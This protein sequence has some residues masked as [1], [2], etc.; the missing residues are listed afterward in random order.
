MR[1]LLTLLVAVAFAAPAS[2]AQEGANDFTLEDFEGDT[3]DKWQNSVSPE[4]Y[5]GGEGRKGLEFIQDPERGGVMQALVAFVDPNKSEPVWITRFIDDPIPLRQILTVSFW[6]KITGVDVAPIDSFK[7]RLRTSPT[8]F[9][10]Y[11]VLP[12]EGPALEQ[13]QRVTVNAREGMSLVNVYR[14][15]FGEVQQLTLRLDDVDER[16]AQFALLVDD[17][18]VTVDQPRAESYEPTSY[19]LRR[20]ERLD[21]LL[22]THSTAGYYGIEQAAR[23]LDP[24]ARVDTYLFRGLHFPLWGFPT[25]VEA[26][27][28]YDVIV[29]VDVDPWVMTGE[30]ATWL[31]DLVHSGAGMLF[32]GGPNTL[33]HA[34][35]FK[36]PL[37]EALPVTFETDVKDVRVNAR[38]VGSDHPLAAALPGARLGTVGSTHA[39]TPREGAQ[40]PFTVGEQP[41]VICGDFGA[42]RVA[43]INAWTEFGSTLRGRFFTSD[44]SD[45]LMRAL[46]SW[47]GDRMPTAR[48]SSVEL[49]PASVVAPATVSIGAAADGGVKQV[50]LKVARQPDQVGA[51]D[52]PVSFEVA[53]DAIEESERTVAC[54]L[55]AVDDAGRI[56]AR[57]DFSVELLNPLAAEV[58]WAGHQYTFAPG[59]PLEFAV[60]LAR[61]DLPSI[62]A[63]GS[64]L[65]LAFAGG[66]LPV[67]VAGLADIWVIPPGTDKTLH[68]Q[69]GPADVETTR[70]YD[71][72]QPV[73]TTTGVTR[74]GRKDMKF[75]DDDRIQR[76]TRTAQALGDGSI[77]LNYH[78]E[79]LQD[80]RL[81]RITTMLS[82]PA[83][84]YAGCPFVAEQ[85]DDRTEGELPVETGGKIFDGTGL[86]L[87]VE[88]PRGPLT[89]EVL[90]PSL[91]V[92]MQDLRRYEMGDFRLEIEAPYEGS[93][94]RK[95]DTY[96]IP[97][98]IS[99]PSV[100]AELAVPALAG[101]SVSCAMVDPVDGRA[102]VQWPGRPAAAE[103]AFS[104]AL[105]NLR[106]GE[107]RVEVTVEGAGRRV[108]TTSAPCYVVDPLERADFFPI[109]SVT[110]TGG[111]EHL[112]DEPMIRARLDDL[113]AHG[114]NT[115]TAGNA[116]RLAGPALSHNS[117]LANFAAS[118]AQQHTM[119]TIFEYHRLTLIGR[120]P[121]KPCVFDPEHER[122]LRAYIEPQF[123]VC[124][125]VPRLLSIK[126]LDEPGMSAKNIDF[127]D[128]CRE[129]FR[130]R[131]GADLLTHEEV[132]EDSAAR[133]RLA[134]FLGFYLESAYRM[135]HDI[136]EES[137]GGFDL[138]L[139]FNSPGLGY[140]R[141][142]TS[143]Q[144]IFRWGAQADRMDFDI[145]PYFYPRSQKVRMVQCDF[146]LSMMRSFAQHINKPWGFYVELDDR[147]W[148]YQQNPKEASAECAYTAI[149][150]GANYLNS[151]IHRDGTGT[152][153]RP[154]RWD[155]TGQEML[156]IARLGPLLT[157][158]GRPPA[159]V[160]M[161]YPMGQAMIRNG[162]PPAHYALECLRQG[163][164]MMDAV[165]SEVLAQTEEISARDAFVLLGCEILEREVADKLRGFVQ[166]GGTL[167]LDGVPSTD[168]AGE[169]LEL[170]WDFEGIE[171]TTLP[172]LA[173]CTYR[174]VE[175]HKG[176]AVLLNFDLEAAYEQAMEED[177]FERA[178]ALRK[179][180]GELLAGATSRCFADDEMGQMEAGL[181]QREDAAMV[182]VVNHAAE[183]NRAS[184]KL[185]A[186]PF[187]P[188]WLCDLATME[189]VRFTAGPGQHDCSFGVALPGRHAQMIAILPERPASVALDLAQRD[190]KP[191]GTL[192]YQIRVLSEAGKPAGGCHLLEVEVT[193]PDGQVVSRFGGATATSNGEATR[194]IPVPVNAL[195]GTYR[196]VAAAPQA[197]ARAQAQFEI[198]P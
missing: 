78:Y 82:L 58:A 182:I 122:K 184:V 70:A 128:R 150:Q 171:A 118:Y 27:L 90:D 9:R 91:H 137:G 152:S 67:G 136:K 151:F 173:D 116:R 188:G 6:Y 52:G 49:P 59:G 148:P 175:Y 170:P 30:Q 92:W 120:D 100:G 55:E 11:E 50:R 79:F 71:G 192:Q 44:L 74:A 180:V 111:G 69:S 145:Y 42:G 119:A 13:W 18:R 178:A 157:R 93:E 25:S 53:F 85:G 38:P 153:S 76:V 177:M 34:K 133:W 21:V 166:A 3:L 103:I 117:S 22:I 97:V 155:F 129:E 2:R 141:G 168:V 73:V 95:G 149:A 63:S 198:V 87:R 83:S 190:L 61:R 96:D 77:R 156:K 194:T 72:L 39:L 138:L 56:T 109:M 140:G 68:D 121:V 196:I 7:L 107:Y 104:E 162:Q 147:N 139:T 33:T 14:G 127:C 46:L 81:N 185:N 64:S 28:G 169:P 179:A 99:G 106:S 37:R 10:D 163:F 108:V 144:D 176:R 187:E 32:F 167:V 165:S 131:Y 134:D 54:V 112:M 23:A 195:A 161:I 29:L 191:G 123:D 8:S 86:K 75:G 146:G 105:P 197:D 51:G 102:V 132:G 158:M 94:A 135:T 193:G 114:F 84:A 115:V 19:Q 26:L 181:R 35:N 110:G 172:G 143:R 5:K 4:Y 48:L 142:Y 98:L 80:V 174:A 24:Q 62:E 17:I 41:L 164:G 1:L 12:E 88:T 101:L 154:E 45:D 125:R 20:D 36:L 15:I 57:R 113:M 183:E 186:L 16:N 40:G 65:K 43:L 126:I 130:E 159:P 89:I 60:K 124:Q 66:E 189:A 31:A 47:A 160:A